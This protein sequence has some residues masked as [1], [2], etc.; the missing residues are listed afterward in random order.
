[1]AATVI[2]LAG[3]LGSRL[4]NVDLPKT[5]VLVNQR[6]VLDH[7]LTQ[8]DRLDVRECLITTYHLADQVESWID[9]NRFRFSFPIKTIREERLAGTR[10]SLLTALK[11]VDTEDIILLLGDV[12]FTLSLSSYIAQWRKSSSEYAFVTYANSY[13]NTCDLV[14]ERDGNIRIYKKNELKIYEPHISALSGI[15]FAKHTSLRKS[16]E[17]SSEID[18][19]AHILTLE[20]L[21]KVLFIPSLDFFYDVGTPDRLARARKAKARDFSTSLRKPRMILIDR[22]DTLVSDP[23]NNIKAEPEFLEYFIDFLGKCNRNEIPVIVL[24]NQ[25]RIGRGI[26]SQQEH[27]SFFDRIYRSLASYGTFISDYF[28]CEHNP[29]IRKC[30][31]RK[32]NSGLLDQVRQRYQDFDKYTCVYLGDSHSD[33]EFANRANIEFIHI[34]LIKSCELPTPHICFTTSNIEQLYEYLN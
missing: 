18:F 8:V 3:G 1:M 27:F 11:Y 28:F 21:H 19:E 13:F 7:I 29:E 23:G 34:S 26:I 17:T 24:T 22:D 33:M 32:P 15:M 30:E 2:I 31:C 16:L 6:P 25:S 20:N 12:I 9:K 5:L 10:S 4:G 14:L